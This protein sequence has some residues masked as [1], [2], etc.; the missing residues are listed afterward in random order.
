METERS[1]SGDSPSGVFRRVLVGFDGS[2]EAKR[3]LRVSR[4]LAADLGG[5]VHVLLVIALRSHAETP[6][7]SAAALAAEVAMLSAKFALEQ[8]VDQRDQ[9]PVSHV[10]VD[11]NPANAIAVFVKEHGF[12][13]VVLGRHGSDQMMHRGVGRSLEAL[14]RSHPCP[15]LV[16]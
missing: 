10:V 14:L 13:L 16:V 5:E 1:N 4:S 2:D 15:I 8:G 6:E 11:D 3:A 7:E 12:D 9:T